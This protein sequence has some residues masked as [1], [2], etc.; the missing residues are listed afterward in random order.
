MSDP[1]TDLKN[2]PKASVGDAIHTVARAGLSMIPFVGGAAEELFTAVVAPPLLKRRDKWMESIAN[3][4]L[5]LEKKVEGFKLENLSQN[6]VFHH[7]VMYATEMAIR[8]HQE[9][10]LE[11]LRNAVLNTARNNAPEEDLQLMF[12]NFV[13][14]FTP[15]YLR[16]LMFLNNPKEWAEKHNIKYQDYFSGTKS[17]ILEDTFTELRGKRNFYDQVVRDLYNRGLVNTDSLNVG[18]TSSGM[19]APATT[20]MGRQF[21]E[22]ITAT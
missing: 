19:F 18:V 16:I 11:A 15:W 13:D 6:E 7:V 4:L 1:N 5:E 14:S 22:Y 17:T 12:L 20:A 21:I 9:E 10:K 8:N 2:K 3:G